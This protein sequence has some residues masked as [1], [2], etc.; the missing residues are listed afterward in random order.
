MAARAVAVVVAVAAVAWG[1]AERRARA[2]EQACIDAGA[3]IRAEYTDADAEAIR[4]ALTEAEST[5]GP[6]AARLV[7]EGLRGYVQAWPRVRTDVCRRTEV[8]GTWSADTG[9]RAVECLQERRDGMVALVELLRSPDRDITFRAAGAVA[10]LDE[11]EPC[12]DASVLAR[13]APVVADAEVRERLADAR[14]QLRKCDILRATGQYA[15]ARELAQRVLDVANAEGAVLLALDAEMEIGQLMLSSDDYEQAR[16]HLEHAYFEAEQHGLDDVMAEA[17]VLLVSVVGRF[18]EDVDGGMQWARH[19]QGAIERMH[20]PE[21]L[22]LAE[23]LTARAHLYVARHDFDEA[24]RDH[25][26]A[27]EIRLRRLGD[28]HTS[29]AASL[30]GIGSVYY[31]RGEMARTAEYV[32]RVLDIRE[33]ALGAQHPLT[34][35]T[36]HNLGMVYTALGRYDEAEA[37]LRAA[38]DIRERVFEDNSSVANTVEALAD[39][40]SARGDSKGACDLYARAL[41]IQE[42]S[43]GPDHPA[44]ARVLNNYGTALRRAGRDREALEALQRSL[45]IAEVSIGQTHPNTITVMWAIGRQHAHMHEYDKAREVLDRAR[46]I[47]TSTDA[48]PKIVARDLAEYVQLLWNDPEG[49]RAALRVLA[50]EA[51]EAMHEHVATTDPWRGEFETWWAEHEGDADERAAPESFAP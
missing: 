18:I 21:E 41:S 33:R 25:E 36:H 45:R 29:V 26:A 4:G 16:A 12:A 27:L 1:V 32:T 23:L 35:G 13:R 8:D 51:R 44:V 39:L 22:R 40:A 24:L 34:A 28:G 19:A 3:S 30:S 46:E 6:T 47:R 49:D 2:S 10:G 31:G 48:N 43:V 14:R 9:A 7:G 5:Y 11:P 37:E 50:A 15:Q 17:A 38:L 20:P 42:E